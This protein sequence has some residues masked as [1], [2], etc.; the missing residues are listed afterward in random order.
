ME[1]RGAA[2]LAAF[3]QAVKIAKGLNRFE[4]E[5]FTACLQSLEQTSN[6]LRFNNFATALRELSRIVLQDRA[7]DE[8]VKACCWYEEELNQQGKPA[9]T[10][11]Q[12]LRYA[13]QAGLPIDFVQ[14]TLVVDV[15]GAIDDFKGL[16]DQ[17]SRFTHISEDVFGVDESDVDDL[18]GQALD[19]FELML[20]TIDECR[21]EVEKT[22]VEHAND[23]LDYEMINNTVQAID[24][25]ATH[26][27]IEGSNIDDFELQYLGHDKIIFRASG[28]VDCQLQYGS[29]MDYERGDGVRCDDNYP[30]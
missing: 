17:L 12:R 7:P 13:A 27:T 6:P 19:T 21:S 11:A 24:E 8:E 16:V 30:L 2:I 28:S 22:L 29:D 23:A 18:V 10:R 20:S 9:I 15:K 4:Q 14:E 1:A 5:L 3:P 25:L 26:H